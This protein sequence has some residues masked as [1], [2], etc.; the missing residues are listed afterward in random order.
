[1]NPHI[2]KEE[3]K[4][5]LDDYLIEVGPNPGTGHLSRWGWRNRQEHILRQKLKTEGFE[6][7]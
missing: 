3:F 1:M 7:Y 5:I 4:R 6:L 2:N